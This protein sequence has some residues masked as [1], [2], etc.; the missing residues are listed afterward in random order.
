MLPAVLRSRDFLLL[1][2]SRTLATCGSAITFVVLPL[3]IYDLTGSAAAL[4]TTL[5]AQTAMVV[6]LSLVGGWIADRGDRRWTII[7]GDLARA[8]VLAA[9]LFVNGPEDTWLAATCA[10]LATGAATLTKPAYAALVPDLVAEAHLQQANA[11]NG[12]VGAVA[13]TVAPVLGVALY[14]FTGLDGVVIG[15]VVSLMA[16]ALFVAGIRTS[17]R[18]VAPAPAVPAQRPSPWRDVVDGARVSLRDSM[19]RRMTV[20]AGLSGLGHG[21]MVASL[22]PFLRDGMQLGTQQYGMALAV[23][24]ASGVVAQTVLASRFATVAPARLYVIGLP[25]AGPLL[26]LA[27]LAGGLHPVAL[28]GA[29]AAFA[30]ASTLPAASAMTLT[31]QHAPRGM[32]ARVF[33]MGELVNHV[34]LL[35][36]TILAGVIGAAAGPVAAFATAG[37]AY[38]AWGAVGLTMFRSARAAEPLHAPVLVPAHGQVEVAL[39]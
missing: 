3:A 32:V 38:V 7:A 20:G 9:L 21:A 34:L 39:A 18:T 11:L 25:L 19:L 26:L 15:T 12:L 37:I 31:Q 29:L 16:A 1:W 14:A 30:A 2:I 27:A 33:A 6:V 23:M 10:A 4:A 36:G 22:V 13:G 35:A 17:H 24:G 8:G 5:G 28:L